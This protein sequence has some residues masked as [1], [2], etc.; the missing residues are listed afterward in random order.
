MKAGGVTLLATAA[1]PR[2]AWANEN[3]AD[4]QPFL[5]GYVG[6][7]SCVAGDKVTFHTSTNVDRYNVQIARVGLERNADK[8]FIDVM[9]FQIAQVAGATNE[10]ALKQPLKVQ[11]DVGGGTGDPIVE[12]ITRNVI[13]RL[14]R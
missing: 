11:F 10:S 2:P 5:H 1:I 6:T 13:D 14:A 9:G 3:D 12:R 8:T 7:R 4:E